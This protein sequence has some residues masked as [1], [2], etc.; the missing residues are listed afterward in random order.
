MQNPDDPVERLSH[1]NAPPPPEPHSD[2]H[3]NNLLNQPHDDS[4][5]ESPESQHSPDHDPQ[6]LRPPPQDDHHRPDHAPP[7]PSHQSHM[8]PSPPPFLP[9]VMTHHHH[10]H[11]QL[12]HY[13][14]C[15]V[16]I[17][18]YAY[19]MLFLR[20]PTP[21]T[22]VVKRPWSTGLFDCLSDPKNCFITAFCPCVTFGQVSEI[23]NEGHTPWWEG[24]MA[25]ILME[26]TTM[27]IGTCLCGWTY[28]LKMRQKH[29]LKGNPLMDFVFTFFFTRLSLCQL[30]RQLDHLGYNV[31][32]GWFANK[33]KQN[34]GGMGNR[35]QVVPPAVEPGM[36]R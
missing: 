3:A 26:V 10:H 36:F 34:H 28:R 25:Y 16:P 4:P 29:S 33:D 19:P 27:T 20:A 6:I 22:Y 1:I 12:P 24:A 35:F 14:N 8:A 2:H 7:P 32:L 13:L 30:Y 15:Q 18:S 5:N 17:P 21:D 9:P 11:L 23:L 31:P